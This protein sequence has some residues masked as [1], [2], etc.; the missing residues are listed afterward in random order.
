MQQESDGHGRADATGGELRKPFPRL[1]S[2]LLAATDPV[3]RA[4]CSRD[5]PAIIGSSERQKL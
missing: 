4:G 2:R 3:A 1:P 5:A